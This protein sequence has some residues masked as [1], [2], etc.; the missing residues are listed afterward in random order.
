MNILLHDNFLSERGTTQALVEYARCFRSMG[1]DVSITFAGPSGANNPQVIRHL[2]NEFELRPYSDRASLASVA[3][4]VDV[5]YMIKAGRRDG[6]EFRGTHQVVH[7][8]FQHADPHGDQMVYVSEW[9]ADATRQWATGPRGRWAGRMKR[10]QHAQ[11]TGCANALDFTALPHISEMPP[12]SDDL[13]PTLGIPNDAYVVVRHGGYDTFDI[14][15]V[16]QVLKVAL[17]QYPNLYFVGL[18]TRAFTDHSRARFLPPST[19]RQ[20]IADFLATGNL[21]LHARKQG[22]SFG[23]ALVEALQM[24]L[25]AVAWSGGKDRNHTHLLRDCGTLYHSPHELRHLLSN[26]VEASATSKCERS[27]RVGDNFR[28][29]RVAPILQEL[30]GGPIRP[31]E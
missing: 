25:P 7:A 8:V 31:S 24:G 20:F 28:R 5:S 4:G 30:I 27:R 17:D 6:I 26:H 13:R 12:R 14:T 29:D 1:H 2:S 10:F 21:F 22:E 3:R 9:L 16:H 23:L 19:D 11:E 15:W 18:N